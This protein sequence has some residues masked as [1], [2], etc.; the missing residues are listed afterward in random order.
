[1]RTVQPLTCTDTSNNV[2]SIAVECEHAIARCSAPLLIMVRVATSFR[3]LAY[4]LPYQVQSGIH[5]E[6]TSCQSIKGTMLQVKPQRLQMPAVG[7]ITRPSMV[8]SCITLSQKYCVAVRN[9]YQR[10]EMPR[11]G[12]QAFYTFYLYILHPSCGSIVHALSES[13]TAK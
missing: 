6:K 9:I 2:I 8:L 13:I 4:H 7:S 12:L 10:S 1:M 5:P 11:G 3:T